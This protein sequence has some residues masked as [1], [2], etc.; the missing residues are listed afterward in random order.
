MRD[1]WGMWEAWEFGKVQGVKGAGSTSEGSED[2]RKTGITDRRRM[3]VRGNRVLLWRCHGAVTK[4]L[5]CC[6][7]AMQ[8]KE[9]TCCLLKA[10][11][12]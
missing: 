5:G 4:E 3:G 8:E 1:I 6:T 7:L 9:E 10:R 2:M 11:L 12:C